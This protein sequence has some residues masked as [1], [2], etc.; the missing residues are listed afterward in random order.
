M[1]NPNHYNFSDLTTDAQRFLFN[2]IVAFDIAANDLA[3]AKDEVVI[4]TRMELLTRAYRSM[5]HDDRLILTNLRVVADRNNFNNYTFDELTPE[6]RWVVWMRVISL[7]LAINN[8]WAYRCNEQS[9]KA[10]QDSQ[11]AEVEKICQDCTEEEIALYFARL[12]K[13]R[14]PSGRQLVDVA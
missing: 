9:L 11:G 6:A 14:S 8:L 10:L 2:Q 13:W 1:T 3:Q 7:Q 5:E 4:S 12:D